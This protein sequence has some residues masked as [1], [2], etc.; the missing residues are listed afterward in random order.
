MEPP[1]ET[2]YLP[3]TVL[4]F[5]FLTQGC[6]ARG[7]FVR[8]AVRQSNLAFQDRCLLTSLEQKPQPDCF[9]LS[10]LLCFFFLIWHIHVAWSAAINPENTLRQ[11]FKLFFPALKLHNHSCG[12]LQAKS[13][14]EDYG[15]GY[16]SD[17]MGDAA[18]RARLNDMTELDRE[19]EL[20]D[21]G[22]SPHATLL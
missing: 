16:G 9:P 2:D 11:H 7:C 14:S 19:L 3:L 17:L 8:V 13:D 21:R 15:D 12:A 1:C 10:A 22:D 6:S 18:D 5:P 20:H 4:H